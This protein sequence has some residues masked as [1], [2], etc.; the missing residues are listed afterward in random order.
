MGIQEEDG[1]GVEEGEES[2]IKQNQKGK[3]KEKQEDQE[4]QVIHQKQPK[5]QAKA[6]ISGGDR[7]KSEGRQRSYSD[8][9][10]KKQNFMGEGQLDMGQ[11]QQQ[12]A[13]DDDDEEEEN[14][15]E[16][17]EEEIDEED[18]QMY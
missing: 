16:E 8:D 2:L 15:E 3:S 7:Q 1:E 9:K 10:Q 4:A 5:K 12:L 14:E 18:L 13:D 11:H 17:E 6:D